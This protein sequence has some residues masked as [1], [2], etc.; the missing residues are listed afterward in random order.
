MSDWSSW[1]TC[2]AIPHGPCD[3]GTKTRTRKCF[4]P[5]GGTQCV[6]NKTEVVSCTLRCATNCT[7]DT[8]NCGYTLGNHWR[9]ISGSTP[10]SGTGPSHDVSGNTLFVI[11]ILCLACSW[12]NF[13][14]SIALFDCHVLL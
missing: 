4:I 8:D 7:F 1:N 12:R 2:V 9:R 10:T 3:Q 13:L 5:T 11:Y 14:D 6:G